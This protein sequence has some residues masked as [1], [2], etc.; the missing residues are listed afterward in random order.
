[1]LLHFFQFFLLQVQEQANL[2]PLFTNAMQFFAQHQWGVVSYG[3][4]G[5]GYFGYPVNI[6]SIITV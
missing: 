6:R 5:S 4:G 1:M 2:S 3:G